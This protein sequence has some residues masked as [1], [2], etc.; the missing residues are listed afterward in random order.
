MVVKTPSSFTLNEKELEI[1][2]DW[3]CEHAKTCAFLGPETAAWFGSPIHYKFTPH[4]LGTE[5]HVG[6]NCGADLY[7]DDGSEF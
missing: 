6:C 3:L 2:E 1:I 4:G 5:I 7:V